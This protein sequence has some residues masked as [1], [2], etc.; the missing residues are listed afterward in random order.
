MRS[1]D[2][3]HV[4]CKFFRQGTCQ[5]GKACPFSHSADPASDQAPCKY[6][7][8]ASTQQSTSVISR[9]QPLMRIIG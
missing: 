6:F 9:S 1:L 8:K 3:S 5:A 4:P 7:Q 2:L